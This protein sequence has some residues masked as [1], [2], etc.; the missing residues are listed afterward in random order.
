MKRRDTIT[1]VQREGKRKRDES[2]EENRKKD[3]VEDVHMN[4]RAA[5]VERRGVPRHNVC[6]GSS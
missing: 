6:S 4:Q 1:T 5:D 2:R 3:N